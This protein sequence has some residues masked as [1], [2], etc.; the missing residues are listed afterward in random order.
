MQRYLEIPRLVRLVRPKSIIEI[1]TWN[2]IRAIEMAK[3][4][5]K[6]NTV[7]YRGYDLFE[8]ATPETNEEEMNVK[9]NYTLQQ[10]SDFL[11]KFKEEN[12]DFTF[13]LI[14]GNTRETLEKD[15]ADFVFIDGGHSVETIQSDYDAVK[16]SPYI[17][18]DDYYDIDGNGKIANIEKFGC[19]KII[20]SIKDRSVTVLPSNDPVVTGG[21]VKLVFVQD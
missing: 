4:A 17:L 13:D 9:K 14:K 5:L 15:K 1:G 2:G 8:D 3:A 12:P 18:F 10:V 20:E 11:G 6:Y 7:Y 21:I 16:E 19:N